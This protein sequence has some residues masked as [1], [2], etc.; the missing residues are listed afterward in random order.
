MLATVEW[1]LLGGIRSHHQVACV[2]LQTR[3]L[4]PG[5]LTTLAPG[6]KGKFGHEES[7]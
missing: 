4:E 3:F 7:W 5:D 6:G 2:D 1:I